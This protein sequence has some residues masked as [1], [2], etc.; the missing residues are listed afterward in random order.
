MLHK[1]KF[2]RH[3]TDPVTIIA[4][5]IDFNTSPRSVIKIKKL[6]SADNIKIPHLKIARLLA[7]K[8]EK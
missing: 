6:R 8:C 3:E 2:E 1:L 4:G 5:S 7:R